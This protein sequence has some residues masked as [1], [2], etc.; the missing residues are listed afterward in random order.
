[1]SSRPL[2]HPLIEPEPIPAYQKHQNIVSTILSNP[3]WP[4]IDKA[5]LFWANSQIYSGDPKNQKIRELYEKAERSQWIYHYMHDA[6]QPLSESIKLLIHYPSEELESVIVSDRKMRIEQ[7]VKWLQVLRESSPQLDISLSKAYYEQLAQLPKTPAQT[8]ST[9]TVSPRR[10]L[11]AMRAPYPEN[12]S[13][14][15]SS[16]PQT[17][18]APQSVPA[19]S[20][21]PKTSPLSLEYWGFTPATLASHVGVSNYAKNTLK[22]DSKTT[23]AILSAH[24]AE[25]QRDFIKIE[26]DR[27]G[28]YGPGKS[29]PQKYLITNLARIH[30]NREM[31]RIKA[32]FTE[33][34]ISKESNW[35]K[36][37]VS[38][39]KMDLGLY[40]IRKSSID[41]MCQ[42]DSK[43]GAQIRMNEVNAQMK[44]WGLK[45]FDIHLGQY[46][47]TIKRKGK[48]WKKLEYDVSPKGRYYQTLCSPDAIEMYSWVIVRKMLDAHIYV[49]PD[50][51]NDVQTLLV[52]KAY[53][54]M[55]RGD[56][57]ASDAMERLNWMESKDTTPPTREKQK[58]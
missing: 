11:I 14:L 44:A 34:I 48:G 15:F 36:D 38:F 20:S 55:T 2:I 22:I 13:K 29:V 47:E 43:T 23:K 18:P 54:S 21:Y 53:N 19:P 51:M 12:E 50:H 31:R 7:K 56:S 17:P 3:D 28:L 6:R 58:P 4:A 27:N 25:I 16:A 24:W 41:D 10:N 39:D 45:P 37:L 5:K 49:P 33:V 52:F 40:Q 9:S 35:N 32:S 57:Y 1:M 26:S 30:L 46:F 8:P 42:T